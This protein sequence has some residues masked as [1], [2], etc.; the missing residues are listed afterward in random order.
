MG[1]VPL[2]HCSHCRLYVCLCCVSL[3]LQVAKCVIADCGHCRPSCR[4]YVMFCLCFFVCI[5]A[6]ARAVGGGKC[7]ALSSLISWSR[8]ATVRFADLLDQVRTRTN[9]IGALGHGRCDM[10]GQQRIRMVVRMNSIVHEQKH[11]QM[12]ACTNS[13]AHERHCTRTATCTNNA[14]RMPVHTNDRT[15]HSFTT[16]SRSASAVLS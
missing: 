5:W 3:G 14:T 2:Y 11:I 7:P 1:N 16:A 10:H 9:A 15:L 12:A 13:T 4:L 6:C 8:P